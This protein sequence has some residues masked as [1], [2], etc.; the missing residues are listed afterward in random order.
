MYERMVAQYGDTYMNH[1]KVYELVER[2]RGGQMSVR[3]HSG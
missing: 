3:V 2:F 1:R